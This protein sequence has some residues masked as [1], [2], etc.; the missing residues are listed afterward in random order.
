MRSIA[1]ILIC[2]SFGLGACDNDSY[3]VKD[4]YVLE[5]NYLLPEDTT[6]KME[7]TYAVR[8]DTFSGTVI[9]EFERGYQLTVDP[10]Y[11]EYVEIRTISYRFDTI[12]FKLNVLAGPSVAGSSVG[13][14]EYYDQGTRHR[15][16]DYFIIWLQKIDGWQYVDTLQLNWERLNLQEVQPQNPN[17]DFFQADP[18]YGFRE[19]QL[20]PDSITVWLR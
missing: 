13:L 12:G 5:G 19:F 8:G 1:F 7:L 20:G 4:I 16:S 9:P 17:V 2:M 10:F 6:G 15:Y 14:E 11:E 3:R 18:I